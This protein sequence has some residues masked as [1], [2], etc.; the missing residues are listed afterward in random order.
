MN[1]GFVWD[2]DEATL[3]SLTC[4]CGTDVV[5]EPQEH[6]E[7]ESN[8]KIECP[9]CNREFKVQMTVRL[10]EL[11]DNDKTREKETDSNSVDSSNGRT[12][13]IRER[14]S[15]A[16]TNKLKLKYRSAISKNIKCFVME[17]KRIYGSTAKYIVTDDEEDGVDEGDEFTVYLEDTENRDKSTVTRNGRKIGE[18]VTIEET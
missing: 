5:S 9:E 10:V 8:D 12:N 2:T 13:N 17:E 7:V 14:V 4:T 11:S 15:E 1:S 6:K 16:D 3:V 18:F